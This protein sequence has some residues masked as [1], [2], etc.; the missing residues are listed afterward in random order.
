MD[1][2]RYTHEILLNDRD[3]NC[4][5]KSPT[6]FYSTLITIP[7]NTHQD[8]EQ[9]KARKYSSKSMQSSNKNTDTFTQDSERKWSTVSMQHSNFL[10]TPR[11]RDKSVRSFLTDERELQRQLERQPQQPQFPLSAAAAGKGK[12]RERKSG[13]QNTT[14]RQYLQ[15]ENPFLVVKLSETRKSFSNL[16]NNKF[17]ESGSSGGIRELAN[18]RIIKTSTN[19]NRSV[20]QAN[21]KTGKTDFNKILCRQ[22]SKS[23]IGPILKLTGP[24]EDQQTEEEEDTLGDINKLRYKLINYHTNPNGLTRQHSIIERTSVVIPD[25]D[26]KQFLKEEYETECKRINKQ[27]NP[28]SKNRCVSQANLSQVK[29]ST[30]F[31]KRLTRQRSNTIIGSSPFLIHSE[32]EQDEQVLDEEYELVDVRSEIFRIKDQ[33][34][35]LLQALDVSL[36]GGDKS[37]GDKT[38]LLKKRM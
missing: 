6:K 7:L 33:F 18:G 29:S 16:N 2:A 20:S 19:R 21:L 11:P 32:D 10:S 8:V 15:T 37:I 4:R 9:E 23:V 38:C 26:D 22:K 14:S 35:D 27:V 12:V 34:D 13:I 28:V 5:S 30:D 31:P 3:Q 17:N 1:G 36:F 24:V 25:E